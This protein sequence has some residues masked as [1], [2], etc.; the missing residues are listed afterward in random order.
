MHKTQFLHQM[1]LRQLILHAEIDNI[2][3]NQKQ[4]YPNTEATEDAE[5]YD[6]DIPRLRDKANDPEA[7]HWHFPTSRSQKLS[8]AGQQSNA[9]H[10][11]A[12]RDTC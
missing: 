4:L 1:Q 5:F 3:V 11:L 2:Q 10:L 6:A 8:H 7:T 12:D 9:A